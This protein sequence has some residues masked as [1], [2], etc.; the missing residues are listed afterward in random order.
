MLKFCH[1]AGISLYLSSFEPFFLTLPACQPLPL[2]YESLQLN[3]VRVKFLA[4]YIAS[5]LL[6]SK[7]QLNQINQL[8][9][10][11]LSCSSGVGSS[12]QVLLLA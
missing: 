11:I 1:R 8:S 4:S 6:Q 12:A 5:T 3:G 10:I 2:F 7:D 9:L